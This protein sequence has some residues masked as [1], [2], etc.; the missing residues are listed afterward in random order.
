MTFKTDLCWWLDA[1]LAGRVTH[2]HQEFRIILRS[3]RYVS[4]E[5]RRTVVVP[6]IKPLFTYFHIYT[7]KAYEMSGCKSW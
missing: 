3:D 5:K 4:P 1:V 6:R 7:K 2:C